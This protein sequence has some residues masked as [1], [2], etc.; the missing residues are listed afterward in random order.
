MTPSIQPA[1]SEN[2]RVAK[3]AGVVGA[4]TLL[5]RVFGF[6]RDAVIAWFF[7]AGMVSDAFFVAFR[8]P[9]LLRRL[10]AEGALTVTFIPVFTEHLSKNGKDAALEMAAAAVKFL[11]ILLAGIAVC[12]ILLAPLLVRI[13]APGF[14]D[15]PGQLALAITL[16]RI[17][18]P[19]IF[20]I[21]LVAI[22]MGILNVFGYFAAPA[23]AP[24]LLNLAIIGSV[25]LISPHLDQPAVG[26]AVG[27]LIG[28]IMQLALQL[29]FLI[30]CGIRLLPKTPWY[31]PALKKIGTLML[32]AVPGAAVYQVNILVGTFLAS[33]LPA[34]SI[35]YLYY[36]DR[37]NQFPL[38]IFA[39]AAATAALPSLSRQAAAKEIQALKR[40]FTQAV[41][42]VLFIVVPAMVGLIVL[43]D[44]IVAVLFK[45][46]AFDAETAALTA[47]A[48]LYYAIGLWA[49]SSVKI[50]VTTFYALQDTRTPFKI[51]A[52][53]IAANMV[54]GILLMG[55][56]GH[57]GLALATSL[58]SM[59][60]LALLCRVL[61]RR[62]GTLD[63]REIGVSAGLT[64]ASSVIMGGVVYLM[65]YRM[66]PAGDDG[67]LPGLAAG[68][69]TG[70]L[71]YGSLS[72][73]LK[74]PELDTILSGWLNRRKR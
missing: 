73:V 13:L 32:P 9:N 54:L 8:I 43:R 62:I 28:G 53:S 52:I 69:M 2:S 57:R 58:A 64:T 17:M 38:G 65:T 66:I 45:R 68:I 19:Y 10:F 29:P 14:I 15:A 16:T 47:S 27:V 24:V 18:F 7:G 36:A 12:G 35:S 25:F 33:L 6:L 49:V 70:I 39:I 42:M 51:G 31:H 4:A 67:S 63:W 21:G 50:V 20:F 71:V 44:P 30:K 5:S 37:L 55:P 40:T 59:L 1:V 74:R 11:A 61:Q 23:L 72:V 3:A 46:G 22:S 60:N 48:V 56:L 34:G 41:K 26:L